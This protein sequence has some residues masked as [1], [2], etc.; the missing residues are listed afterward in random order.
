M[1]LTLVKYNQ[2]FKRFFFGITFLY[3]CPRLI[4]FALKFYLENYKLIVKRKNI[5]K[6]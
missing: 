5:L 2:N 6:A 4:F 1:L 3:L